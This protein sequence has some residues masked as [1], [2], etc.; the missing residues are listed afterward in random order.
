MAALLPQSHMLF[1][2]PPACGRHSALGAVTNGIKDRVSYYFLTEEDI[3]S[4]SY[5][6]RIF[7]A[8]G[9]ML[10]MLT[11]KP[12]VILL[13]GGCIDDLL[14]TDFPEVTKTLEKAHPDVRFIYCHMDPIQ[15]GTKKAPGITLFENIYSLLDKKTNLKNQVNLLGNNI[16]IMPGSELGQFFKSNGITLKQLPECP[17]FGEFLDMG[18]SCLNIVLSVRCIQ[19]A[20]MLEKKTGTPYMTF[21]NSYDAHDIRNFYAGVCSDLGLKFPFDMQKLEQ[22]YENALNH[23]AKVLNGMNVAIDGQ[24]VMRPFSLARVLCRHGINVTLV[25]ADGIP[26]FEKDA[27]DWLMEHRPDL[28]ILDPLHHLAAKYAEHEYGQTLCIGT[29]AALITGSD[30]IVNLQE[31]NGLVCFDGAI[32][33]CSL[34]EEACNTSR[35]VMNLI[36]E[37]NLVV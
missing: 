30:K 15:L 5:V 24:A 17:S 27:F 29:E 31:D 37:A 23:T 26:A 14:G 20:I 12:K 6:D 3:V 33:L 2:V 7:P 36:K 32:E 9:Q 19:A 4:G 21:L 1:V 22:D 16:R 35:N 18:N 13:F 10:K 11:P 28:E 34:I 8:V 25:I